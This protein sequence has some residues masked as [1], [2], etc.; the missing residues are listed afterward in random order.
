[1]ADIAIV[2]VSWNCRE[3]LKACLRSVATNASHRTVHTIVVDN[4]SLDG[5]REMI[6]RDFAGVELLANATNVGFAAANN[7]ALKGNSSQYVLLLNPDT[8]L[9]PGALDSLASFMDRRPEIWAAGPTILNPDG[10]LQRTGVRFPT[11]WNLLVESLFLDRLFPL[12]ALFGAHRELYKNPE[13]ARKVDFVQGACL[14]IRRDDVVRSAGLLDEGFFM[15]F[16]ETD[17]C[18]RIREGGGEVWICPEARV[19]HHGGGEAGH[20]DEQRLLHYH[21]SMFRFFAKH[22]SPL[23]GVLARIIVLVRAL[24]RI[25][26]WLMIALMRPTIRSKALSSLLGYIKTFPLVVSEPLAYL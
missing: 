14:M 12:S 9:L 11:L 4:A 23:V 3:Y 26:V 20:Y 18:Y 5:T 10:S 6:G 7:H 2:I 19:I 15:Y 1:M 22:N 8:E 25:P 13:D 17:W 16:E 21:R 24:M